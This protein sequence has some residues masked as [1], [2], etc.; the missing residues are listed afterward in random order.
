[1]GRPPLCN[2][3]CVDI[4]PPPPCDGVGISCWQNNTRRSCDPSETSIPETILNDHEFLSL[5]LVPYNSEY[6]FLALQFTVGV[7]QSES[8]L[9]NIPKQENKV[10]SRYILFATSRA[11]A[12]AII[13]HLRNCDNETFKVE[14][15]VFSKP[16]IDIYTSFALRIIPGPGSIN[17]RHFVYSNSRNKIVQDS[18]IGG[19]LFPLEA[20][21]RPKCFHN[22]DQ[23]DSLGQELIE[24][25]YGLITP[26]VD[27]PYCGFNEQGEIFTEKKLESAQ[28]NVTSNI[29]RIFIS[30]KRD[31]L[32]LNRCDGSFF[33]SPVKMKLIWDIN[34]DG[35]FS[36]TYP[37]VPLINRDPRN[38]EFDQYPYKC[39][40][41]IW[42][43][44]LDLI[45]VSANYTKFGFDGTNF[46]FSRIE[47]IT[48]PY[49]GFARLFFKLGDVD[50]GSDLSEDKFKDVHVRFYLHKLVDGTGGAPQSI[51][52]YVRNVAPTFVA[53]GIF[54]NNVPD[55]QLPGLPFASNGLPIVW[56]FRGLS[57][58]KGERPSFGF[59]NYKYPSFGNFLVPEE[60]FFSEPSVNIA[61]I[62][63]YYG[64]CPTDLPKNAYGTLDHEIDYGDGGV[65]TAIDYF[66]NSFIMESETI[67]QS[68]ADIKI[69]QIVTSSGGV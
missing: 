7:G 57:M 30:D 6:D 14:V 29:G 42:Y 34:F 20:V 47:N 13:R 66:G 8:V 39:S 19:A 24:R 10:G 67:I 17:L 65:T 27:T 22:Q 5:G 31:Y 9:L 32:L 21:C 11:S 53:G 16:Y 43:Y 28:V 52:D 45:P 61:R 35:D 40:G 69:N 51:S 3:Y 50:G 2:C 15:I 49:T 60:A 59:V 18:V 46:C 41:S 64:C 62:Q 33:K 26:E 12:T 37:A 56:R 54:N 23:I 55:S 38:I 25:M 36:G 4:P 58:T 44:I 68:S 63:S 48:I 1:M